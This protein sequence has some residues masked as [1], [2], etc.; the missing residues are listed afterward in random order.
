MPFP[1]VCIAR[2]TGAGGEEVGHLV[3]DALG[4][5][6]VDEEI[7]TAAAEAEDLDPELLAAAERRREG[8]ARFQ[9]D[10]VGG[11]V[12]DE[13]LRSLIRRSIAETAVEG[14]VVIV[15]HAAAIALADD[16]RALRVLVTASPAVRAGRLAEREQVGLREAKG[17]VERSDKG[18]ASYL[19]RFYDIDRELPTHYDLVLNTDRIS[20]VAAAALV[21]AA[22][23]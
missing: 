19:K 13:L 6:Y 9:L 23:Q 21:V 1:V 18:R 5:R 20:P 7:L 16:E 14:G 17:L 15:A 3:A 8:V 4:A 22:A 2:A 10:F 12:L 11:G